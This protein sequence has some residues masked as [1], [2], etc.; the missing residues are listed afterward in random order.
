MRRVVLDVG[1]VL[2]GVISRDGPPG[3]IL[4]HWRDGAF[5][6]VVSEAWLAEFD[7]VFSRPRIV[8][9]IKTA[10]TVALRDTILRTAVHIAD[11]PL[12]TGATPDPND[13]Y[14]VGLAEA[15]RCD[16]LISGDRH[17]LGLVDPRPPVL[18][19]RAFADLLEGSR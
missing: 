6:V 10:A 15:G 18:T 8:K 16:A 5:D 4:T 17:L 19:P 2:S 11:P 7:D 13:D 14:L 9:A 1:V 3:R 12:P